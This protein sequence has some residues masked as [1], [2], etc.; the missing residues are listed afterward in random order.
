MPQ[1]FA[2]RRPGRRIPHPRGLVTGRGHHP[3]AVGAERRCRP[4]LLVPQGLP[5]GAPVAASHTRAVLS[6]DAVTTRDAV[7]AEQRA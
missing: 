5:I 4:R 1:G 6:A 3:L 2:D 7:G